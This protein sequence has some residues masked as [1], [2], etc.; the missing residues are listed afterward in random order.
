MSEI[1]SSY[2]QLIVTKSVPDGAIIVG[3]LDRVIEWVWDGDEHQ[4]SASDTQGETGCR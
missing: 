3:N 1:S 2:S 4:V